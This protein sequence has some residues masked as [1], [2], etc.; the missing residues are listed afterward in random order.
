MSIPSRDWLGRSV[1]PLDLDDDLSQLFLPQ[2]SLSAGPRAVRR[3]EFE[4]RELS[5]TPQY[6]GDVL[7]SM[8]VTWRF[9]LDGTVGG[10]RVRKLGRLLACLSCLAIFLKMR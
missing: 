10:G 7:R 5:T 1:G 4:T 2:P 9:R 6:Q 3:S 8:Q